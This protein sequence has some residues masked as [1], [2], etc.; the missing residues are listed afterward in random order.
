MLMATTRWLGLRPVVDRV[1]SIFFGQTFMN[2][3]ARRDE[4]EQWRRQLT[5][6][7]R[8]VWRAMQGAIIRRDITEE[9]ARIVAPTL[10][11]VGEED[12]VTRPEAAET[13][14]TRI[15]GA[16]LVRMPNVGHMSNLEQPELVNQTIR[17]FLTEL[18]PSYQEEH[19]ARA[20]GQASQPAHPLPAC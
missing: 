13:L 14:H 3:P 5:T 12:V 8:E 16:Q 19:R 2:D 17:R 4:R 9:L 11:L 7:P 20:A 6:N 10:I 1:M 18:S 15:Q